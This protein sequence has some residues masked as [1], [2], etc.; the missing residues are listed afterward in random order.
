[1]KEDNESEE[2]ARDVLFANACYRY[3][4]NARSSINY[5]NK[6]IPL[7][8]PVKANEM[9]NYMSN[10]I[11]INSST[12]FSGA[13]D[14]QTTTETNVFKT[15]SCFEKP[16]RCPHPKIEFYL[17][18]RRTQKTPEKL[19]VLDPESFYYTRFNRA[20]P[21]KIVIHGFGGGRNLSPSTDLRDAYF[22]R[23]E[24]NIIIVDY[25]RAV[26]EPCLSQMEWAPRFGSLCIAQ[27]VKYIAN[28]PRGVRPDKMHF[29]GYSVGAHIAGLIANQLTP[30]DGK[31]GRITGLDP[32][33]FFY[34][35]TN[36]TRD[37][38]KSDAH[39]VDVIHTG[40]GI[41]GQWSPSGHADF[42]VNGG[43]SQPGCASS[44]L[45]SE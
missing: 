44:T 26:R 18:T 34:S 23:G 14:V 2:L 16:Y 5:I 21:T 43:T 6:L 25:S 42:Y 24:Y 7:F 30:E 9:N 28:H 45:F 31:I 41:L 11:C 19:N 10:S 40:A 35:T 8:H 20:H 1:M 12:L 29:I 32:T 36:N 17:Y 38:D 3:G 4:S 37:L 33:I 27:L 39:F 13:E 15:K 22:Q